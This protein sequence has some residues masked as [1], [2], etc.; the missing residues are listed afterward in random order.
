MQTT[1]KNK[2]TPNQLKMKSL[3]KP[4][5]EGILNESTWY[6]PNEL[7][8]IREI[9]SSLKQLCKRVADVVNDDGDDA[10]KS[11]YKQL[12]MA[13]RTIEGIK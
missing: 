13:L 6:M 1:K 12:L 10:I 5:V 9:E 3:L 7:E 4:I 2:L 11:A 8:K